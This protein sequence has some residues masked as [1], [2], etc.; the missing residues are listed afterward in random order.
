MAAKGSQGIL[1]RRESSV[2]GTPATLSATN[3]SQVVLNN[4]VSRAAGFADFSTGMRLR[5]QTSNSSNV[6]TIRTTAAAVLTLREPVTALAAGGT[7]VMTGWA[8]Q[9]IGQVV[10]FNGPSLT[11]AVIDVTTLKSTAKEKLISIYDSGQLSMSVIYDHDASGLMLHDALIRDMQAR[12]HRQFDIQ[13]V[14]TSTAKTQSIFFGG[15][16]S[17][18]N[19]TGSVDNALKAD[20]TISLASG[21]NFTTNTAT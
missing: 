4:T 9:E 21:V 10:S 20:L 11:A 5:I 17:G 15:Y 7:V 12:T 16:I 13:I 1:L 14:G 18:F 19:I 2:A 6:Y 3:I 8:M